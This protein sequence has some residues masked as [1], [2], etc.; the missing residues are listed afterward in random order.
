MYRHWVT[1][2]ALLGL[3]VLMLW[4]DHAAMARAVFLTVVIGA[5]VVKATMIAGRFMHL[6]QEQRALVA[7]VVIGLFVTALV[8]FVLIVPDA[9][10]I[11]GMLARR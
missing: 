1:W 5:M 2:A 3:T 6:A 11:H 10:R 8:L 7:T 9:V 4:A